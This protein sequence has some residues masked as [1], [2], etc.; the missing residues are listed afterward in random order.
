MHAADHPRQGER[1]AA[2]RAYDILDTP[3]ES[4][5]DDI[6]QLASQIC[7]TPISVVNLIDGERQWFKAE[8]GLGLRETPLETSICAHAI[9]E[10]DFVEIADTLQDRRMQDNALCAGDSGLRFY[11]GALLKSEDGL[12]LGTLCVLDYQPRVLTDAQRVALKVLARQVMAQLNLRLALARQSLL[13]KE[14]DHRVK[15]SLAS[16]AALVGLQISR[17]DD[18]VLKESLKG[19]EQR[20]RTI[21][22]LHEALY[23]TTALD[24]VDLAQYLPKL[25]TMLQAGAPPN[26]SVEFALEPVLVG[27]GRASAIGVIVSEFVANSCK[28]A[29]PDGAGGVVSVQLTR[30]D[31]IVEL[32]CADDGV[33]DRRNAS[34]KSRGLGLRLIEASAQSLHGKM[35]RPPTDKGFCLTIEFPAEPVARG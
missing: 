18:Q 24:R 6:V 27:S 3:R 33:G 12:P 23:Q 35:T 30:L 4:D 28:H 29:F 11:A 19:V 9:L 2:L 20:I 16:V 21:S 1:L 32:R 22:L 13:N 8:V 31:D 17:A 10:E 34:E 26:V 7:G 5:F 15:N 14:V 25:R